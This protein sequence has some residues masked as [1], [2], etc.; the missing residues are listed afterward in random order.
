MPRIQ[1]AG[2]GNKTITIPKAIC[3]LLGWEK[4]DVVDFIL[5]E[6]TGTVTIKRTLKARKRKGVKKN[7]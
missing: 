7:D 5:D 6:E 4:G 3:K 2:T 1:Q